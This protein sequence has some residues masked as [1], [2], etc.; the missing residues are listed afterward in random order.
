MLVTVGNI[1]CLLLSFLT[2]RVRFGYKNYRS[3][4]VPLKL[5]SK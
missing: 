1:N 5:L 3:K 4:C 2:K